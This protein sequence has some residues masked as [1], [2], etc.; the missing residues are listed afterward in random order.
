MNK[1]EA[2]DRFDRFLRLKN[3]AERT[4]KT[5]IMWVDRFLDFHDSIPVEQ[6][7]IFDAQ[8]YLLSLR[9]ENSFADRTYNQAV[10]ALRSFF[11]GVLNQ[12][13]DHSN[14]PKI[15]PV[16][17]EKAWFT[18]SQARQL[19]D[20]CPDLRLKAAIALSYGSGL[21]IDELSRIQIKHIHPDGDKGAITVVNSKWNKTRSRGA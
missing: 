17:T 6:L 19:I 5:Y 10:Y 7:T 16:R 14:L 4:K 11:N 21:R 8:D 20:D 2:L 12:R 18:G 9:D 3:S 13:A 15:N 1:Q